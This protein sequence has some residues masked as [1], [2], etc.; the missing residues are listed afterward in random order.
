MRIAQGGPIWITWTGF[1]TLIC[2]FGALVSI[3]LIHWVL[4]VVAVLG[5]IGVILLV[6]FF[7]DPDRQIGPGIVAVA[8]GVVT[9]IETV[10]DPDVGSCYWIK[11]FLNIHN[12]HVQRCPLDGTV[13]RVDH[14]Q[15]GHRP[16]FEKDS[17]RNE[18]VTIL[19]ESS[20]GRVKIV[21]I[22]GAVARRI[23]PY[24]K[25]GDRLKKGDRIGLI[26]LGSRTDVYLPMGMVA[27]VVVHLRDRVKA[28]EDSLAQLHA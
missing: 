28:G 6:I 7:R 5:V 10:D 27:S 23:V 20:R 14:R 18:R 21:L 4:L 25:E 2:D 19:L 3:G 11:T 1:F 15:G 24:V 22:A 26:R 9:G 17:E 8:D 12:V 16:A 13:V